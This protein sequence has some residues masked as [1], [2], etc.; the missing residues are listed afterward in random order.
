VVG[1]K[2]VWG[3]SIARKGNDE[4]TTRG[5]NGRNK[6]KA[7]QEGAQK[8]SIPEVRRN[9]AKGKETKTTSQMEK[10]TGS[11]KK[12]KCSEKTKGLDAKFRAFLKEN[13]GLGAGK[14]EREK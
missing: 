1:V 11:P 9:R 2:T 5:D 8:Q 10:K 14:N 7:N 3:V 13:G 4:F 6:M 12:R